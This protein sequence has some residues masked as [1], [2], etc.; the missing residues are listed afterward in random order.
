VRLS[1]SGSE[2]VACFEQGPSDLD[3]VITG[4]HMPD[5]GGYEV[6]ATIRAIRPQ[7]P[8]ILA[9]AWAERVTVAQARA[10]RLADLLL[11]LYRRGNLVRVLS[12]IA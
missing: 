6:A 9:T 3:A 8:I 12:A 5:L 1:T 4:Q 10:E 2:A 11:N 7:V